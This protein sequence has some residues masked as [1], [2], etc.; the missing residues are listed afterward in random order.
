M[1]DLFRNTCQTV[2]ADP[3][4]EAVVVQLANSGRRYL[5]E[6]GEVYKAVARELPVVVSFVGDDARTGDAQG[7]PR[8]RRAAVAEPSATMNALSLL[9]RLANQRACAS[10]RRAPSLPRRA[11][12]QGWDETMAFCE[13]GGATPAKWVVLGPD[14][15]RRR[16][17]APA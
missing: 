1:H 17:P 11:A 7:V 2:A 16:P 14:G 9:Y 4:T 8:R 10:S 6:D 12:P 13:D 5:K 3:R 15:S